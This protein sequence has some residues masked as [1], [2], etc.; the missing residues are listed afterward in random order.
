MNTALWG[1]IYNPM[2][3]AGGDARLLNYL[4]AT[5]SPDLLHP[6]ADD[7]ALNDVFKSHPHLSW[8]RT[9][10][11]PDLI[12]HDKL[13]ACVDVLPL[14]AYY[15][16]KTYKFKQESHSFIA[17]WDPADPLN[18][19][20]TA[21]LG[22]YPSTATVKIDYTDNL[23]RA[24]FAEVLKVEK[25]T[26]IP[27]GLIKKTSPLMFTGRRLRGGMSSW[28]HD[29]IYL[30]ASG[31]FH[32]LVNFWNL[33][34]A[35]LT[36]LFVARTGAERL[37]EYARA[38]TAAL[39]EE[40]S[41]SP[42]EPKNF[43]VWSKDRDVDERRLGEVLPEDAKQLR[44]HADVFTWNGLNV[45]PAK[46][47]IENERLL[48]TIDHREGSSPSITFSLGKK[49]LPD[50]LPRPC[51][52]QLWGIDVE[53]WSHNGY[54]GY[55]LHPPFL[56]QLNE[57]LGRDLVFEPYGLRIG[58]EKITVI[59]DLRKEHIHLHPVERNRLW[60]DVLRVAGLE[61]EMSQPGR[62][63]ERLIFQVGGMEGTRVFKIP[64][65]RKLIESREARQGVTSGRA[66]EMIFDKLEDG[67]NSFE[68]HKGLYIEQRPHRDLKTSDVLDFLVKKAILLPGLSP[69]CPNCTLEYWVPI[70]DIRHNSE[71]E[72]CGHKHI[73]A[74]QIR[75]RGDWRFR[76]SG[77]FGRDDHQQGAVAVLLA[78]RQVG[79]LLHPRNESFLYS[80]ALKLKGDGVDC[81]ADLLTIEQDPG[82]ETRIVLGECKTNGEIT[83]DDI[84]QLLAARAAVEKAGM[85]CLLLFAKTAAR[86]TDDEITRF[87]KASDQKV[88]LILFTARELEPYEVYEGEDWDRLPHK[89]VL[90]LREAAENSTF[91]YLRSAAES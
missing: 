20:F 58:P 44:C 26:V 74:L 65:V 39:W 85:T 19:L 52:S 1:G 36:L 79:R 71:C 48:A 4:L 69:K 80:T 75:D 5:F 37:D 22:R 57:T 84:Q 66:T 91:R 32:D 45:R 38:W 27:A 78:L 83:D 8:P 88:P 25:D 68:Q 35:G 11:T 76:L 87:K 73:V 23:K 6:I 82:G 62:I 21:V 43:A 72:Y 18:A 41:K 15:W 30:G 67:S 24:I 54:E 51:E 77:L 29:G 64:G 12:R 55:I 61:S 13:L 17:H 3:P 90:N 59:E 50:Q 42:D 63:A 33:R 60:T 46:H 34:A 56:P 49:P 86:F 89:H 47:Y 7:P 28:A 10:H 81:E 53:S 70:N 2:L 9:A 40:I 31:D 14:L 16:E